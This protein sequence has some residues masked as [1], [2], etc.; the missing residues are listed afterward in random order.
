MGKYDKEADA[1][2]N[3]TKSDLES[4]LNSLVKLDIASMFPNTADK[5]VIDELVAM[6]KKSADSNEKKTAIKALALKLS[7]EGLKTFKTVVKAIS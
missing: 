3:K 4:E 6:H 7:V 1:A 5:A 2:L